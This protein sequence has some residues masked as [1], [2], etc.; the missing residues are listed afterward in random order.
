MTELLTVTTTVLADLA[1]LGGL[2]S[3]YTRFY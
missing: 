1:Q 2:E 3:D